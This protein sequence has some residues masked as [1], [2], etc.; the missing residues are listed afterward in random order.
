MQ[1]TVKQLRETIR[2]VIREEYDP[3]SVESLYGIYSDVYKEKHG[4]R[5]RWMRP[6]DMDAEGWKLALD[7]LYSQPS[8][9]EEWEPPQDDLTD[10]ELASIPPL[11]PEELD[12][13]PEALPKRMGMGREVTGQEKRN[14][15]F[16][17]DA[18]R[19]H[20]KVFKGR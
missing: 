16:A 12:D 7:D 4:I 9:D 1:I 2:E 15:G 8:D 6:E 10:A 3:E 20:M 14:G 11:D 13:E 18:G 19:K 5:P 17:G